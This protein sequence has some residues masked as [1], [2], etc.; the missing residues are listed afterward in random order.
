M[1]SR[2]YASG[3]WLVAGGW[4]P[5]AEKLLL[6]EWAPVILHSRFRLRH[7]DRGAAQPKGCGYGL[8]RRGF[9]VGLGGY[10]NVF[11]DQCILSCALNESGLFR[12]TSGYTHHESLLFRQYT[13]I[14]SFVTSG[15]TFFHR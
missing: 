5:E 14:Y 2:T 11:G 15:K 6:N 7:S 1:E 10:K 13:F 12:Q 4:W 3:E 8:T 9:G